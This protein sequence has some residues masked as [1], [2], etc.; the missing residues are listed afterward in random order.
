MQAEELAQVRA[1]LAALERPWQ[2]QDVAQVLRALGMVVSDA[3]VIDTLS[4]LRRSSSGLGRLDDLLATPGLTDVLVNGADQV[5]VDRGFGL[6]PID[7]VFSG[8]DEVRHLATR[9]AA[10]VG[11]RLDDACPFVDARLPSGVRFHAILA[12][13]AAPGTCIS[14]RIPGSAVL[15]LE[16]WLANGSLHPGLEPVLRGL[17]EAKIAFVISG[18]TGSGKTTLMAALLG[19]VAA[20]QRIVI[21]EDSRE[22]APLHPHTVRL[23]S[24][25]ANAEGSGAIPMTLLVKQALRMR[26]DRLVVGEVRGAEICDFLTALNTGHEGGCGTIH[27]N[28]IT[29]VP[30]RMEA[31]AA[32]GGMNRLALHAQA[33]AAFQ[34][35]IQVTRRASGRSVSEIGIFERGADGLVGVIPAV[36][37]DAGGGLVRQAAWPV[38]AEMVGL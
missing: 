15:G 1:R 14:L 18:G 8:E 31:L 24:R 27:A 7:L 17:V 20:E 35:V 26:P 33:A 16:G 29:G 12:P 2:P 5:F 3:L 10:S 36:L 6:E 23:E 13:T 34:V 32:L 9:L 30:A 11:R 25:N 19:L 28:S 4:E 37:V 22:L 21:V 38:L